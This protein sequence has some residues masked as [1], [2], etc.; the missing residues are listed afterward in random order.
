MSPE[1]PPQHHLHL[2]FLLLPPG[3]MAAPYGSPLATC[4]PGQQT[5][6]GSPAA[7]V[8]ARPEPARARG[9]AHGAFLLLLSRPWALSRAVRAHQLLSFREQE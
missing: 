1:A 2:P 7:L 8:I 9:F 3:L 4:P 5:T 6:S